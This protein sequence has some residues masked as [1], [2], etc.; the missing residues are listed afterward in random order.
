VKYIDP[1][2]KVTKQIELKIHVTGPELE[3]FVLAA[4]RTNTHIR[5]GGSLSDALVPLTNGLNGI[6]VVDSILA[7]GTKLLLGESISLLNP[8]VAL[9]ITAVGILADICVNNSDKT[10]AE[11]N[12]HKIEDFY[13]EVMDLYDSGFSFAD[14]LPTITETIIYEEKKNGEKKIKKEN[15][16]LSVTMYNPETKVSIKVFKS[17]TNSEYKIYSLEEN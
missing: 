10:Q 11:N 17:I 8:Y 12:F 6:A 1:D 3:K 9:G 2:G 14:E 4:V 15:L 5:N 13:T 16:I 7:A